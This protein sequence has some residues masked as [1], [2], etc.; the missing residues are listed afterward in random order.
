MVFPF[1]GRPTYGS[2]APAK[3]SSR[4]HVDT[5]AVSAFGARRAAAPMLAGVLFLFLVYPA[6]VPGVPVLAFRDVNGHELALFPNVLLKGI[7]IQ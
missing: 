1:L 5:C 7:I 3:G 4:L 2:S 6:R